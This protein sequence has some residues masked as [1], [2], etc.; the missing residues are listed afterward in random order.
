MTVQPTDEERAIIASTVL[1]VT[2]GGLVFLV[3]PGRFML[4]ELYDETSVTIKIEPQD[5]QY[6]HPFRLIGLPR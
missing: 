5:P 4:F 3:R 1:K 6:P 2:M